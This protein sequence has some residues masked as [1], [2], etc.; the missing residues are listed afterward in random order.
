MDLSKEINEVATALKAEILAGN[1]TVSKMKK[2]DSLNLTINLKG[3]ND[4]LPIILLQKWMGQFLTVFEEKGEIG[5]LFNFATL[6][7][8]LFLTNFGFFPLLG[9]FGDKG[10]GKSAFGELLQKFFSN[11]EDSLP[12][13][14]TTLNELLSGLSAG[15][16]E[17]IFID[18]YSDT[19]VSNK[20]FNAL[21]MMYE[22]NAI[23]SKKKTY[24]TNCSIYIAGECLP[25][26]DDNS[27]Q[28]RLISLPFHSRHRTTEQRDLLTNLMHSSSQ[29]L[30]DLTQEIV[31]HRLLFQNHINTTYKEVVSEI[32]AVFETSGQKKEY[33]VRILENYAVL[34]V[35]YRVLESEIHFPFS[36]ESIFKKC[37]TGVLENSQAIQ[38]TNGS[39]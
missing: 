13:S 1:F 31:K 21:K 23:S 35:T 10:S 20:R 15:T 36:Y 3:F 24:K 27:L 37:I 12:L 26:K 4:D 8:D 39:K 38:S 9:G 29:G 33:E 14:G 19:E 7:R 6:F 28:S 25:A 30:G 32:K 2:D 17:T 5:I 16:N 22:W 34:L 11:K 18:D